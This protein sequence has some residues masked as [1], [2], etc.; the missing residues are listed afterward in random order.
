MNDLVIIGRNPVREALERGDGRIEK[1]MLQKGAHGSQIDAIRRAAKAAGVPTQMV[2]EVRINKL[3]PKT[4]HQGVV[5]MAAPVAYADLDDMLEQIA[6]NLDAV[7]EQKPVLLALDGI[8][9]PHNYGAILR[10]AVASGASGVVVPERGQAP[11]SATAV[12]A[13]AGTALRIP[14]ARV[15]NLADALFSLKERG[16]WVVGLDGGVAEGSQER[17][18]VW[19]N[20]WDRPVALVV[21][22]E[23][24]GMRPRVRAQCD[25]LVSIPIAGD[26]ESLNASVAAGIVLFVAAKGR[27]AQ[28]GR[29]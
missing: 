17:A 21:G 5:A 1:V 19:D 16:Y 3:A 24:K 29:D 23:G 26:V 12:K 11:L 14:I 20:D 28:S 4:T 22:S 7:R 6:P 25:V 8:E 18:T 9:D 13:S 27:T 15:S 10:S 2:P